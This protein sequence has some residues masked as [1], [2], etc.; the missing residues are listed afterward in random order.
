MR[1]TLTLDDDVHA[2]LEKLCKERDAKFKTVVNETL[3]AGLVVLRPPVGEPEAPYTTAPVDL[4]E[5]RL[6]DVDDIAEVLAVAEGE[7]HR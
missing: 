7:D 1:T 2:E 5:C 4:G 6:P 3:R